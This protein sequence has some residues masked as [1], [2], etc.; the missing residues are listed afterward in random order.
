MSEFP[1]LLTPSTMPVTFTSDGSSASTKKL[2]DA[3]A[4]G[5]PVTRR[6]IIVRNPTGNPNFY[7][8]VGTSTMSGAT[9]S[10]HQIDPSIQVFSVSEVNN[11][12]SALS[13]S[14]SATI[15]VTPGAGE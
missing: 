4:T 14:G 10:N 1:F 7:I 13:A 12:F 11:Y 9:S 15:T 5:Q 6:Q 2:W 8:A 3:P